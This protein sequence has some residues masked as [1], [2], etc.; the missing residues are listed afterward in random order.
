MFAVSLFRYQEEGLPK[1]GRLSLTYQSGCGMGMG[2]LHPNRRYRLYLW[3][4]YV[5]SSPLEIYAMLS[6]EVLQQLFQDMSPLTRCTQGTLKEEK[7]R[8]GDRWIQYRYNIIQKSCLSFLEPFSISGST[9][10]SKSFSSTSASFSSSFSVPASGQNLNDSNESRTRNGSST[11]SSDAS[12]PS[13]ISV[14]VSTEAPFN[15]TWSYAPE[16]SF[17]PWTFLNQL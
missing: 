9:S 13:S 12:I 17:R 11:N 7:G 14:P 8:N 4:N 6:Q 10:F 3:M 2:K 15:F 1:V 5:F 16:P